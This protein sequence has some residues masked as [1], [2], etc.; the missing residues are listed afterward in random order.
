MR[1]EL[2]RVDIPFTTAFAHSSAVRMATQS[3]W[4]VART[5]RCVGV[6]EGCPREYVTGESLA[7]A[8][9]FFDDHRDSI[10]QRV[11]SVDALAAWADAHSAVIDANPAAWCAVELAVLELFARCEDTPLERVV[12]APPATGEFRYSAVVGDGGPDMFRATVARYREMGFVEFKL[13]L[14]GDPVRDRDKIDTLRD[15]E[16]FESLRI[17]VDANNLWDDAETAVRHL[18]GLDMSFV[19]IEEPLPAN[20]LEGMRIVSEHTGSP[21]ILDESVL[22][23]DQMAALAGDPERWIINVRVSKMGGLLRS[24]AL[25]KAARE[26]GISIIVGAHVGETSVLTRAGLIVARAAGVDLLAQ[27][28]AFGTHLLEA[29][30]AI[31]PLMFG[32]GGMLNADAHALSTKAG[33]GLMLRPER[34]FAA[35]LSR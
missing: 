10:C 12:G 2:Y 17:R 19:G 31:P 18:A 34:D 8:Q 32:P 30:V 21:I 11:G 20:A 15:L 3:V 4:V 27:E 35:R 22:R 14:S 25:V 33:W 24:L 6:G 29:D 1:L 5:G 13:K 16:D 9:A 28:G 23:A 7:S 26:A